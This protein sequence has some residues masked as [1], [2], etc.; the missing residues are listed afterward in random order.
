MGN[1]LSTMNVPRVMRLCWFCSIAFVYFTWEYAVNMYET[2][3][4]FCN[5]LVRA[6]V[7]KF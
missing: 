5:V 1:L 3:L 7:L 2:R 4:L 6:Q